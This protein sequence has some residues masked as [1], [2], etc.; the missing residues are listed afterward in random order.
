MSKITA[1]NYESMVAWL[2]DKVAK[3]NYLDTDVETKGKLQKNIDIMRKELQIYLS[4]EVSKDD[5]I[6]RKKRID[7]AVE[8]EHPLISPQKKSEL[9]IE[10]DIINSAI[11]AYQ[12]SEYVK[13]Y[14]GV[15]AIYEELGWVVADVKKEQ[16][17][18]SAHDV[19][20]KHQKTEK[21]VLETRS[22]SEVAKEENPEPPPPDWL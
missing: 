21:N 14:P 10:Y 4:S 19:E 3:A 2:I 13:N 18:T 20:M 7:K 15:R 6:W 17:D 22:E 11:L 16:R 5:E 8:M 9:M 12:R 1:A